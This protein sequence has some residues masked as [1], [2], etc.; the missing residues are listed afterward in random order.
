M[1]QENWEDGKKTFI[2]NMKP[3]FGHHGHF[4]RKMLT[5]CSHLTLMSVVSRQLILLP[6]DRNCR[7]EPARRV[8]V[9]GVPIH[10]ALSAN[11]APDAAKDL[12]AAAIFGAPVKDGL[13]T[14]TAG[15]TIVEEAENVDGGDSATS[16]QVSWNPWSHLPNWQSI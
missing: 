16:R 14:A 1:S 9:A 7:Q 5:E 12:V 2:E 8:E 10:T 3:K 6:G 11:N 13:S 4:S 15:A